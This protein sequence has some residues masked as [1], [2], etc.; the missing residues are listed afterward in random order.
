MNKEKGESQKHGSPFLFRPPQIYI[1]TKLHRHAALFVLNDLAQ[2]IESAI[3]NFNEE[4][5][6]LRANES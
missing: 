6:F 1:T 3:L 4:A 2:N 5:D